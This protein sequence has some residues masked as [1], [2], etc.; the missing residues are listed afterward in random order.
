MGKLNE[1]QQFL[2]NLT[3]ASGAGTARWTLERVTGISRWTSRVLSFSV[4]RPQGYRFSPGHYARVGL[5][6]DAGELVWR[7]LSMVSSPAEDVLEFVAVTVPEG[8][9]SACLEKL[10]HN[11]VVAIDKSC[12]G[13]LTLDQLARGQDI[14]LLASG[15]GVG[16]FVSMLRDGTVFDA[17]QRINLAHSVRQA[18]ELVYRDYLQTLVRENPGFRYVPIVTREAGGLF[19]ERIP[20]LLTSGRL[21]KA[22]G[23]QLDS[24]T[25]R[26]MVCGN[27]EMTRQLRE[28]LT[29]RGFATGRR[30]QPGQMAFE[31]YW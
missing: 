21:E 12:F 15:T 31:K 4:T 5:P 13:F 24:A 14:W 29:A 11:S 3:A 2:G 1:S 20:D 22:T 9:F 19:A 10:A 28:I 18:E 16:P 26:V 6:D 17:F 8:A 23:V 30:G 27:P 25:S 7:P